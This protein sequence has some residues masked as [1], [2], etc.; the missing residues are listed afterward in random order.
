MKRATCDHDVC[1]AMAIM[2]IFH[3]NRQGGYWRG[4]YPWGVAGS[5]REPIRERL[6]AD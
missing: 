3:V 2:K 1:F 6:A 5:L 4:R